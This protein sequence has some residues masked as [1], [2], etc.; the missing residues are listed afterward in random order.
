MSSIHNKLGR[1]RKPRVHLRYD[2]EIGDA[3][4][5]RELPFVMGVIGDFSGKPTAQL[6]P[7]DER[8]FVNIDRDNI[9][10]VLKQM[11]PGL[12]FDVPNALADDG[13]MMK[14]SLKFESM[15]D[16]DPAR[17]ANQIE[18]L[19]KLLA[20]RTKLNELISKADR[21]PELAGALEQALKNSENIDAFA[22]ELGVGKEEESQ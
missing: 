4:E 2:V 9:N 20:I 22:Q 16:F 11:T 3:T 1:V 19:K 14:V 10:Q 17:V 13:S 5:K 6:K 15:D 18:P 7:L 12:A 8:K 21:S